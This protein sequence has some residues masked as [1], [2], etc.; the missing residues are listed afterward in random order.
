MPPLYI[1][2]TELYK[3]C[4][5]SHLYNTGLTECRKKKATQFVSFSALKSYKGEWST[6]LEWSKQDNCI[7]NGK[8]H[9][10][11]NLAQA[12]SVREHIHL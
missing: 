12:G 1:T 2:S 10:M 8:W 9:L 7:L 4:H 5:F 3:T 6:S 11:D